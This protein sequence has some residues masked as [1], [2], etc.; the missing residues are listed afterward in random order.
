MITE[1]TEMASGV[2]QSVANEDGSRFVRR[3]NALLRLQTEEIRLVQDEFTMRRLALECE[4]VNRLRPVLDRRAAIIDGRYEPTDEESCCNDC[5]KTW[6]CRCVPSLLNSTRED[7]QDLEKELG[8][9][10]RRDGLPLYWI[11]VFMKALGRKFVMPEDVAVLTHLK[12]VR[13]RWSPGD[14][15]QFTLDFVFTEENPFFHN[16]VLSKTLQMGLFEDSCYEGVK[17]IGMSGTDIQWKSEERNVTID[18]DTKEK[19][20][21]FFDFF[22]TRDETLPLDESDPA[23]KR[24]CVIGMI[25]KERV[26]ENATMHFKRFLEDPDDDD[27]DDDE[28][29]DST[30]EAPDDSPVPVNIEVKKNH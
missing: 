6:D 29:D 13:I 17:V 20:G 8:V 26:V 9:P 2:Q 18:Q 22:E 28:D 14:L 1:G 5:R 7:F 30:L 27:S 24:D 21:S 12:D 25:C 10:I 11:T 16:E 19:R 23:F 3:F 4:F 15:L